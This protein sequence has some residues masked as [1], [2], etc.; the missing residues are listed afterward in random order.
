MEKID[1]AKEFETI[2]NANIKR[3][4][5]DKLL[6]YLKTTDFFKAPAST[7]FHGNFEGGLVEHSVKLYNRFVK[8]VESEEK[9]GKDF[10]TKN[11]ESL[12]IIALLHDVCKS[13]YYK[14]EKR[15]KK[16]DGKWIEVDAYAVEDTLPY[17][18]GEKSVYIISGFMKL[19]RE[20]AMAINWHMGAFDDRA[21]NNMNLLNKAFLMYPLAL[22]FHVSDYLVSYLDE[23]TL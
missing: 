13:N 21:K 20:E 2:Y 4:G 12:T 19:T 10:V 3:D 9:Y 7:R 17:G 14:N 23:T 22:L 11:I 16:V 18:H 1:Y 15:N 5:A 8:M 6:E